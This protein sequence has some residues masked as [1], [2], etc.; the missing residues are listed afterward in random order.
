MGLPSSQEAAAEL[1]GFGQS[2]LAQYMNGKIPLNVDVGVKLAN[3]LGVSLADFSPTLVDQAAKLAVA[4]VPHTADAAAIEQFETR[5]ITTDDNFAPV[6]IPIKLVPIHL[7]AGISNFK[8]EQLP[9]SS[10]KLHID[11]QWV[12][13]NDLDPA[14]LLG[15]RVKGES[16]MPLMYEGD[17]AVVNTHDRRRVSGGVFAVNFNG[18]AVVKRLKYE[19]RE[20]YLTSENPEFRKELCRAGECE[21]VGRVVRFEPRNF[22]DRL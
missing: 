12:E 8:T 22:K 19:A 14:A 10:E 15:I 1:L 4:V 17:I 9:D 5:G 16:M 18:L 2:A 13:E 11:R 3:L 7:Q 6:T 21:V 20:W